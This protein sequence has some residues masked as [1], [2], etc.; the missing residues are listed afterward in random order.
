MGR[1]GSFAPVKA[2]GEAGEANVSI[3]GAPCGE[4]ALNQL[5]DVVCPRGK[6]RERDSEP[7]DRPRL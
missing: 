4:S 1:S 2:A 5:S 3:E 6:L 7:D